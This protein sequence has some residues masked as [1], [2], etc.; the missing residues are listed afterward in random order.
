LAEAIPRCEFGLRDPGI[1]EYAGWCMPR[2]QAVKEGTTRSVSG[3]LQ[4]EAN[5]PPG[6]LRAEAF[7]E[8]VSR[9]LDSGTP[10]AARR[11]LHAQAKACALHPNEDRH[12]GKT[13]TPNV[14]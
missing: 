2:W 3:R 4:A 1:A 13:T 8:G 5:V 12:R 7:G 11:R 9:P 6:G 10:A 14:G